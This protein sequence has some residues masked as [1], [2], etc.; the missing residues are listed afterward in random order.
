[1][2]MARPDGRYV[3]VNAAGLRIGEGHPRA[4]LTDHKVD[5]MRTLRKTIK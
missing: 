4:R 5:L 3:A 1:M 2:T